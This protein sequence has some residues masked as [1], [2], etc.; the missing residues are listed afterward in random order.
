MTKFCRDK[1]LSW[2]KR[3]LWQLSQMILTNQPIDQPSEDLLDGHSV[4]GHVVQLCTKVF[5]KPHLQL[6]LAL[7]NQQTCNSEREQPWKSWN[8]IGLERMGVFF[9]CFLPSTSLWGVQFIQKRPSI[10]AIF[11]SLTHS[12]IFVWFFSSHVHPALCLFPL[13]TVYMYILHY[14]SSTWSQCT[15]TS[16]T[17]PLPL[18][19]SM[20]NFHF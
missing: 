11:L 10:I 19:H 9:V 8:Y 18:G 6:H 16:C 2:Q 15:C 20:H 12:H 1:Y 17:L 5:V 3:Y 7:C 4:R 13:L 14:A